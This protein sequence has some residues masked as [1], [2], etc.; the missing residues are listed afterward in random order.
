M[1]LLRCKWRDEAAQQGG[2]PRNQDELAAVVRVYVEN[3]RALR[4]I[5]DEIGWP[6]RSMVGEAAASAAWLLAQH[7]DA[8]PEFQR[9]CR[10]L[11]IEAAKLGEATPQQMA[12]LVDRCCLHTRPRT[13]QVYGT[14][15]FPG[16]GGL[17]LFPVEDPGGLDDRRAAVGL[18]PFAEYDARIRDGAALFG[19]PLAVDERSS[20]PL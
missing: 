2:P 14:Q 6:G 10:D 7:S 20:A 8:D 18:E 17:V 13:P 9:R 4:D 3:T 5:V 15:Y 12:Y 19:S 16:D 1:D 11:A